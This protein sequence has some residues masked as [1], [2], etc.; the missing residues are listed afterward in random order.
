[1]VLPKTTHPERLMENANLD[2]I[3]L[4]DDD[5]ESL[6]ALDEMLVTDW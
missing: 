6:S 1:M 2:S 3:Q 4:P 5:M